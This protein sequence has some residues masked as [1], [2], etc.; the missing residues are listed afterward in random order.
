MILGL[1]RLHRA[2]NS[3]SAGVGRLAHPVQLTP[4][5]LHK[6]RP[7]DGIKLCVLRETSLRLMRHFYSHAVIQDR[8]NAAGE[9]LIAI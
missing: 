3:K 4:H 2:S 6:E 5:E 1:R 7:T 9:M 8:M